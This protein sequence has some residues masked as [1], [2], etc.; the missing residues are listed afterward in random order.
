[1]LSAERW[2][3][4]KQKTMCFPDKK[5]TAEG[6]DMGLQPDLTF[7]FHDFLKDHTIPTHL[8]GDIT[9]GMFFLFWLTMIIY[10]ATF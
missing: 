6:K 9:N 1:M 2:S 3:S 8:E 10:T 4:L 5:S 7:T